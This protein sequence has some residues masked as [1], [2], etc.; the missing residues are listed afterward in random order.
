MVYATGNS[1]GLLR[2]RTVNAH[3]AIARYLPDFARPGQADVAPAADSAAGCNS[4]YG[5]VMCMVHGKCL[6]ATVFFPVACACFYHFFED[7]MLCRLR[8]LFFCYWVW[9]FW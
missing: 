7:L 6:C 4:R 1:R 2:W 3:S 8:L 9:C 5:R